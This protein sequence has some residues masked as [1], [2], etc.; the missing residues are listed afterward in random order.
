MVMLIAAIYDRKI[1]IE[2]A[3]GGR[4]HTRHYCQQHIEND[5]LP[6]FRE[7]NYFRGIDAATDDLSKQPQ[8]IP[9]GTQRKSKTNE[10]SA[11]ALAWHH[12]YYPDC[13]FSYAQWW[14]GVVVGRMV[15]RR[16]MVAWLRGLLQVCSTAASWQAAA[17]A[18][19]ACGGGALRGGGV[20]DLV[21]LVAVAAACVGASGSW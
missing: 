8:R 2:V 1:R 19:V 14:A 16:A 13:V 21:V 12:H 10:D 4:C 15:S 6:N 9:R 3:M 11:A 5:I 17:G 7:G 20:V 18:A